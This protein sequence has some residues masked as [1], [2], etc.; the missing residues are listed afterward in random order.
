MKTFMFSQSLLEPCSIFPFSPLEG[1]M[2]PSG[3]RG[4]ET[5]RQSHRAYEPSTGR[6]PSP[7]RG[8]VRGG[9]VKYLAA[10]MVAQVSDL[11]P[12]LALP[13]KGGGD[14]RRVSGGA[15]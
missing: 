14:L 2:S 5:F 12:S 7:L 13:L 10:E 1:E 15:S 3:D 8:G 6:F 4:G 9:G 11:P